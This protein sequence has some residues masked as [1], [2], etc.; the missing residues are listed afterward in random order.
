ML[1]LVLVWLH[2]AAMVAAVAVFVGCGTTIRLLAVRGD[3]IVL[4]TAVAVTEPL[5]RLGGIC[6]GVGIVT[7]L[8]LARNHGYLAPWLIGAYALTVLGAV[9]G[10]AI[11]GRWA[12]RLAAAD[13]ASYAAIRSERVPA[14]ASALG[15]VIWASILWLMIAKPS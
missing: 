7:G 2:V 8:V 14:I 15:A 4:R 11:D 12:E 6:V 3:A 5:F 1:V 13:D 10:I 9:L